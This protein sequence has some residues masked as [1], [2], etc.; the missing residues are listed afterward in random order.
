MAYWNDKHEGAPVTGDEPILGLYLGCTVCQKTSRMR[1]TEVAK[2][3]PDGISGRR[4]ARMLR[5]SRCG[6]K[7]GYI[8][9]IS[10]TRPPHADRSSYWGSS[11]PYP[12]VTAE[13]L[14]RRR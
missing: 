14:I 13:D 10:E 5:C 7:K 4:L 3:W 9:V 12:E 11:P 1:I 8:H 6:E 2:I